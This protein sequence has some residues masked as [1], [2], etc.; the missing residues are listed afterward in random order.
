[1]GSE[2]K[3][4][5]SDGTDKSKKRKQRY[6]PHNKP[7]RKGSFPLRPGVEGFF[8]TS[9]GGRERQAIR[10]A[11]N[12]L[13]SF[14]EELLHGG[15]SGAKHVRGPSK[16]L[17]KIIKF[18]D[19]DSSGS[20]DDT[21]SREED[22]DHENKEAEPEDA[23]AKKQCIET[24]TQEHVTAQTDLSENSSPVKKQCLETNTLKCGNAESNKTEEKS[25]D[26]QIEDELKE[27]GDRNKRH[28]VSLDSGCNGVG[29]I[30]MHKRSGDPGPAEIVQHIMTSLAATR[31]HMSRFILRMLPVEVTCHASEEEISKAIKPLIVKY[32]PADAQTAVKFAVLYDARA[33]TGIERM[34]IINSV[35]KSVPEP[36]KVDLSNPDKTIIVQ[37]AKTICMVGVVERYKELSKFNIRQLTSPKP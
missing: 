4:K 18:A 5:A 14:L 10:E 19:S 17:N 31:K 33:N 26:E 16:P 2:N 3:G 13:D 12:I 22:V 28:F 24:E 8:I 30:Q 1:M 36:H 7:V 32:F 29:F 11:V 21:D 25:I 20:D 15:D 37:V 34:K 35:A 27:L 23:P 6:L 9:D